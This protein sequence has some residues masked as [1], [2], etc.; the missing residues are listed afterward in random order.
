MPVPMGTYADAVQQ[1]ICIRGCTD[2]LVAFLNE[3]AARRPVARY[4]IVKAMR[5]C[6]LEL[7]WSGIEELLEVSLPVFWSIT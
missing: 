4:V 7:N 6:A 1:F 5:A 2:I 3:V